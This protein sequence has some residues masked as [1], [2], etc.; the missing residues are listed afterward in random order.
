MAN[1][2]FRAIPAGDRYLLKL[3]GNLDNAAERVL[4]KAEYDIAYG[5]DHRRSNPTHPPSN[6]KQKPFFPA[7]A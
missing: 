4:N 6:E 5:N 3:R 7:G 1:A 2:F